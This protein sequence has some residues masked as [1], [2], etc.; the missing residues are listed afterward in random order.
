MI[1]SEL[2][3]ILEGIVFL[4]IVPFLATYAFSRRKAAVQAHEAVFISNDKKWVRWVWV[5]MFFS[6]LFLVFICPLFKH[7][8]WPDFQ[9][10]LL[11]L[12]GTVFYVCYLIVSYRK[13]TPEEVEQAKAQGEHVLDL[14]K[15]SVISTLGVMWVVFKEVLFALPPIL[16]SVMNPVIATKTIGN[17]T[18]QLIGTSLPT[19]FTGFAVLGIFAVLVFITAY[20]LGALI[21]IL[22]VVFFFAIT[23]IKF[24]K[25]FKEFKRQG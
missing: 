4:A 12:E 18:Y 23:V 22:S 10:L 11:L 8:P 15:E 9:Y 14:T 3:E 1:M 16:N 17:V 7:G 20:V 21:S 19:I 13:A 5:A 25:N 2:I 24:F 6:V